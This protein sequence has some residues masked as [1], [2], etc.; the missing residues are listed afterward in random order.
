M[1]FANFF[2]FIMR[3]M[4]ETKQTVCILGR[5]SFFLCVPAS[6]A[7]SFMSSIVEVVF[8][9]INLSFFVWSYLICLFCI[10]VN[11]VFSFVF[12]VC[13]DL[14]FRKVLLKGVR[15]SSESCKK[16]LTNR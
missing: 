3:T 5:F 6:S 15:L 12:I 14:E 10:F 9:A 11:G 7:V 16:A 1:G 13:F 2:S 8:F 4:L